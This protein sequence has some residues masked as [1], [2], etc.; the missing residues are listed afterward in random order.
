MPSSSSDAASDY[1]LLALQ[2]LVVS[3][4]LSSQ[5]H[6]ES[7]MARDK[8]M[9]DRTQNMR[10]FA[11]KKTREVY[12]NAAPTTGEFDVAAVAHPFGRV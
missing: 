3:F 6:A 11:Q 2:S 12:R 8:T 1:S 4:W 5:E 9:V 7:Q 10:Q